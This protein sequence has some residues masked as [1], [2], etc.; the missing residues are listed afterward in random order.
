MKKK[1]LKK[2]DFISLKELINTSAKK[3]PNEKAF[4]IKHKNNK[5]IS[6]ENITYKKFLQDINAFGTALIKKRI[7]K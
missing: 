3:Y 7:Q 5:D 6:Y 4:I 1:Y 2:D